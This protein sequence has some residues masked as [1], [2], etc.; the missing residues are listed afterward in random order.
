MRNRAGAVNAVQRTV[1][2]YGQDPARGVVLSLF[3]DI[4]WRA[5]GNAVR[6]YRGDQSDPSQSFNGYAAPIQH[7]DT[8]GAPARNSV[9]YKDPVRGDLP[10]AGG[11]VESIDD[12]TMRILAERLRRRQS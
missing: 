4:I 7:F 2:D 11:D 12:P 10:D 1:T 9:I 5:Q 3:A 6:A 8:P